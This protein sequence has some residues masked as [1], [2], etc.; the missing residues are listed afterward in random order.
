MVD[1]PHATSATAVMRGHALRTPEHTAMIYVDDVE[2]AD[3]ATHWSYARLD[4]EA[5]RIG[6]WLGARYPVG[7]RVLLLYPAGLDFAA[8]Y[9][10][11]LYAGTAAVPAP[12][13]GRYR[14]EQSRVSGIARDAA[15]SVILTD[16]ENLPAVRAWAEAEKLTG[17]RLLATDGGDLP[18]PGAWTP[19]EVDH[20]TLAMLQYTSGSTGEPKGVMV[21]HGNLLHNVDSQRRAFGLT[22]ASRLGG[23]IPHYHD[24]GLLGQ[25]LPALLVGGTCVLMRPSAFLQRPHNWLRLIDRYD[26]QC[27]AAPNFAYEMCCARITDEQ[28]AG[29]DLSRW[30]TASN[31]SERVDIA[32]LDAFAK[33]FA[34]AG[35]RD[36]ALCPCYGMAEATVFVSGE[37]HRKAVVT[38]VD[39]DR[40]KQHRF[41]PAESGV[42]LVSCGTPR[43]HDVLIVDPWTGEET[44]TGDVGEIWLRGPSLAGEYWN[45]PCATEQAFTPDGYLRTGDLGTVHDGELYVTGRLQELLTVHGHHLY[46]QDVERE[47]RAHHPELAAAGAVFTVPTAEVGAEETLVVTHEVHGRPAEDRLRLLAD[48]IRQTVDREFGVAL[49][50]V[51]LLRRGGVRRTT[52]GKIRRVEMRRLFLNGELNALYADHEPRVTHA[53]RSRNPG[54]SGR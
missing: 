20:R 25:L 22:A 53:L 23:W 31:G 45:N 14:H 24:M 32:T 17:T 3:G 46:P 27:S 49:G 4:A 34:P 41:V 21:S 7:T 39:A 28:L 54:R 38:T 29:L 18:D 19:E 35:L 48:G 16:T 33:R 5:T 52:S 40:L 44:A 50:G 13:P 15:A 9:L 2:R 51:A 11:C 10:G 42:D 8:A 47:L 37:A 43:D 12:L 6:A 26:I 30:R 1:L 36:D